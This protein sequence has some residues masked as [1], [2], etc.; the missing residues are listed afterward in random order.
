MHL[1]LAKYKYN[2]VLKWDVLSY[3]SYLPA[4][5]IDKDLTLKF[6]TLQNNTKEE[7]IKYWYQ[8]DA[9]GNRILKYSMG[10]SVMYAPFFFMAHALATPFGYSA[11]GFSDVYE[12]FIE[13]S[14]LFYLLFGLFFLRKI[15]LKFYTEQI[16]A[17]TLV[18]IFFGTNVLYYSTAESAMSHTYTFSLF[19]VF[20]YYLFSFY[21][22]VSIKSVVILAL[23]FGLIILIRPLNILL[24][25]PFLFF[26]INNWKEIRSRLAFIIDHYKYMLL[27][28]VIIALVVAPQFLY[29]KYVTGQ[30][31]VFSYGKEG[32][33][34]DHFHVL[35]VLFSF[36]K[37]WLIY[38]PIMLFALIGFWYMKIQTIRVFI[39]PLLI[40]FPI[41]LYVVSS[42]WCWWYGGSF[43]QRS[44]I[45]IYPLLAIPLAAFLYKLQGFGKT[46]KVMLSLGIVFL[47]VLNIFQTIQYKYNIIDY[48]GMT[49]K[50]YIH[51]F[52][53]LDDK[54]IDATLLNKPDYEKAIRGLD[55]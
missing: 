35:D 7:G 3:Y 17:V 13:F 20:L 11:D 27:F 2:D 31:L 6:V 24:I 9:Q 4:T 16:T 34:F 28:S 18:L 51:V 29:Y 1:N 33:Y 47:L 49:S 41:Y 23:C 44:L 46:K 53:T 40:L 26:N 55:E 19:S 36:R 52:G 37:G 30:Y 22:K 8:E 14:G 12:F 45:D 43:S 42:W 5:F 21:E 39:M 25:L 38:T 32:F 50:E 15:L 10:M 48:D 54:K